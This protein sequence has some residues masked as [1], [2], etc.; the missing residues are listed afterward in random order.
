VVEDLVAD[1]ARHFEALLAGDRVDDYVAVDADKVL[2]IKDAILIL[3]EAQ[4][5][6]GFF[7]AN[8]AQSAASGR[9]G[10]LAMV[11]YKMRRN[12]RLERQVWAVLSVKAPLDRLSLRHCCLL[13]HPSDAS[14]TPIM[15]E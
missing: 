5:V 8:R 13:V 11:G 14:C 1:D 4:I 15:G 6:S 3:Q 2:R 12:I 7:L 10:R 9:E